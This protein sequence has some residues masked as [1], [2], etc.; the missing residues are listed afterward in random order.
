MP[1]YAVEE[2]KI[3][4]NFEEMLKETPAAS[5]FTLRETDPEAEKLTQT[6]NTLES[7]LAVDFTFSVENTKES[8]FAAAESVSSAVGKGAV[9]DVIVVE[10]EMF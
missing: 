4:F 1:F 3:K 10:K 9:D 6:S 7:G 2:S 5:F 8:M